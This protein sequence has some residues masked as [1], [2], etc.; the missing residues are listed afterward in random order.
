MQNSLTV[1]MPAYNEEEG[2]AAAVEEVTVEVLDRMAGS[3]LLVVNDGSR[4]RTGDVLDEFAR[5]DDRIRV[6]HKKNGGHGPAIHAGLES[7]DSDM[8]LL[9][10]SDQQIPLSAFR[11]LWT[12]VESG[13]QAAFGV[14][15][16]RHDPRLRLVLT[17]VIRKAIQLLFGV[18]LYDANVPFKLIRREHWVTARALIPPETLAP[19]LFLAILIKRRG[20]DVVEID[21]PHRERETG[22]VS[23]RRWKLLR[24]CARAFRQLMNFRLAIRSSGLA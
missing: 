16:R 17:A 13:H 19:S 22:E 3:R 7:V 6:L 15:R 5:N 14:R 10:D 4:D 23:I 24:F 21:V 18:R 20:V 8:V 2:I 12:A 11:D 9:V 1:L